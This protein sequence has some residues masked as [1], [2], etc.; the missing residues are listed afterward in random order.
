MVYYF[1]ENDSKNFIPDFS[2]G[3][4]EEEHGFDIMPLIEFNNN[5]LKLSDFEKVSTLI[6]SY[7]NAMSYALN[8][9]ESVG[10]ALMIFKD[11]TLTQELIDKSRYL[12]GIQIDSTPTK[13]NPSIEYLS[14]DIKIDN[15]ETL[16][17]MLEENI[18]KFS[19]TVD[20]YNEAFS[21]G[22][23]SGE[24]RKQQLIPLEMKCVETER[25]FQYGLRTMFNVI[26]TYWAR[27]KGIIILPEEI[28]FIF[29][30]SI[31]PT[32]FTTD[33]LISLYNSN[34]I[35][36]ET[37]LSKLNFI[38]DP[39]DEIEKIEGTSEEDSTDTTIEPDDESDSQT[40]E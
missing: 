39:Q 25:L 31:I 24:S 20:I 14:K 36:L 8:D 33:M 15:T 4:S 2:S 32:E 10:N 30:R 18:F 12:R 3:I 17:A 5:L 27:V 19:S 11:V 13:P 28:D 40:Q 6:D 22:S 9:N 29:T 38:D 35:S 34:I 1:I 7:D 16:C 37:A 23:V 26:A 21:G